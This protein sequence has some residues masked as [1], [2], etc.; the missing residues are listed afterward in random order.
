MTLA[1]SAGHVAWTGYWQMMRRYHRFEVRAWPHR[2]DDDGFK[3]LE[4]VLDCPGPALIVGYHGKPGAR[5]LIMLQ[6]LLL[7]EYGQRTH[8]V[9]HDLVFRIPVVRGLAEGMQL[10][11]RNPESIAAAVG[12]GEKLVV[13]PGGIREAW[14][15][16]R[17]RYKIQ[18]QSLGYLKLA[19][20]YRLPIIPVAGVGSGD[21]FYGAYDA[22]RLW[23]P[24]WDRFHL[25][26]GTGVWLGVGPFGLWP[27]SPPFP[28]RISQYIG[29]PISL[30]DHGLDGPD[31]H[32]RFDEP[33][34]KE[35]ANAFHHHLAGQIQQMLDDGLA[36]ARGR[37]PAAETRTWVDQI[38]A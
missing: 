32:A 16:F 3:G 28:A 33:A 24:A 25:P 13:A 19:A 37:A 21:A 29:A 22:Y 34:V 8:A 26:V 36:A 35:R 30:A 18:W 20:R 17:D 27:L 9:T 1:A 2:E 38:S 15:S 7:T 10:V 11:A 12:R 4:N 14:A 6:T 23:K 31:V 5:D